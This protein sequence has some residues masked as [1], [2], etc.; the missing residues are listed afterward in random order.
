MRKRKITFKSFNRVRV[1][2]F[3]YLNDIYAMNFVDNFDTQD[4]T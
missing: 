2:T 3:K 1:K 4:V